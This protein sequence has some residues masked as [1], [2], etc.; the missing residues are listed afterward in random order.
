VAVEELSGPRVAS[1]RITG[2]ARV[3]LGEVRLVLGLDCLDPPEDLLRGTR[4]AFPWPPARQLIDAV[5]A[6]QVWNR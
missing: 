2:T 4:P 6:G 1:A 5:L 3:A